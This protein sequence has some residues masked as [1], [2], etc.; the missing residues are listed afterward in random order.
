M[1]LIMSKLMTRI[2]WVLVLNI[3]LGL[4]SD[5]A[6]MAQSPIVAKF[7]PATRPKAKKAR[8]AFKLPKLPDKGAPGGRSG[9]A[10]RGCGLEI[11]ALMPEIQVP[12]A[13]GLTTTAA[14]TWG[15]TVAERPTFWFA[16]SAP[17]GSAAAIDTAS[18][19][20]VLQNQAQEDLYR[21]T[22][23]TPTGQGISQGIS[24]G[25]VPVHLPETV[26]PLVVGEGYRWFL[27]MT[28]TK[29]CI[30]GQ[31]PQR[32]KSTVEGWVYRLSPSAA[33]TAQLAAAT[34]IEQ[35][36]LYAEAGFW[37][38]AVTLLGPMQSDADA[39]LRSDW[40]DLLDAVGLPE[41]SALPIVQLRQ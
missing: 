21:V 28:E 5:R 34:P 15:N 3:L 4:A 13:P 6:V 33:L 32:V 19:E 41:L 23:P 14:Q 17:T 16:V 40:A 12:I 30:P 18:I 9:N 8:I 11:L 35:A 26:A 20:F 25:I 22:L 1:S 31:S 39:G 27:T 2:A 37:F 10:S 36:A 38:D 7:N 24:K 29:V